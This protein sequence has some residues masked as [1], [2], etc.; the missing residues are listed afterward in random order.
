VAFNPYERANGQCA[1]DN[2]LVGTT[3]SY[4]Y[5]TTIE[6]VPESERDSLF[7]NG[8][9][10]VNDDLTAYSTLVYTENSVTSRIAPYPTGNVPLPTDSALVAEYILPYLTPMQTNNLLST[11][12]TW[13]ALPA[14]P[15]TTE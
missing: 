5:T 15:R 12:G 8:H 10:K 9:F 13:R 11:S 1:P 3:C 4:D 7:L 2:S 14:E 6:I